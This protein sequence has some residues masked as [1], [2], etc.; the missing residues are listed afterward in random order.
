MKQTPGLQTAHKTIL[1]VDDDA[2]ILRFVSGLLVKYST[3]FSS[4][5]AAEKPFRSRE[6]A[7]AQ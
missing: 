6:T 7:T 1:L 2:A 5:V 3:T 4:P